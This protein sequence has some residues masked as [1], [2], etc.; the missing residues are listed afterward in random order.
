MEQ[1]QAF[2]LKSYK[3]DIIID[4]RSP[5]EFAH[6]HIPNAQN[7]YA[8]DNKEYK[9]IGTI[10]KRESKAKAKILGTSYICKNVSN[11]L[12]K[13]ENTISLGSKIAI[14]CAR[15][16]LRS[17]SIGIILDKIGFQVAKIENGYK[18][19]RNYVLNF[20]DKIPP[21]NFITLYGNTGCGKTE[22]IRRLNPSIDLEHLAN[23]FGSSFGG[24]KGKQPSTKAFQNSLAYRLENLP[25]DRFCFVEGESMRIGDLTL[26]KQFYNQ[27]QRGIKIEITAPIDK[28]VN[29]I[30][31]D[32]KQIN[33]EF[34]L[35][36]MQKISPYI[37][38]KIKQEI[39]DK[40]KEQK[41]YEVVLLL[42]QEYYDKAYKKPE[43]IDFTI[44]F[45]DEENTLEKLNKI[46]KGAK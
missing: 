39:I 33:E 23:H 4:A 30:L 5:R 32:Y 37:P 8:L 2:S 46:S 12:A 41:L 45:E 11:H 26:P 10:Y 14:Y 29:R 7:Y 40:F 3:P 1:I 18:G 36:C 38:K 28:R 21:T 16:G 20:L 27:M 24:I 25:T 44:N 35:T 22:L 17:E 15:G 42:L 34:F 43:N 13:I 19:Y 9:N 31:N 6:S